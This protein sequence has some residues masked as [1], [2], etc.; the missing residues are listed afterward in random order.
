[1]IDTVG[2]EFATDVNT[3]FLNQ[4]NDSVPMW[5][6]PVESFYLD[7]LSVAIEQIFAKAATPKEALDEAQRACQDEL[8]KLIMES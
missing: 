2:E 6:S 3:F 1:M 8:D 5:N 7:Q 4:L